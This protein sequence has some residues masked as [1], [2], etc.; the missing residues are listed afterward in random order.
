VAGSCGTGKRK[1]PGNWGKRL[2][3]EFGGTV[4]KKEK[5]KGTWEGKG[6]QLVKKNNWFKKKTGV[7]VGG[8]GGK[9]SHTIVGETLVAQPTGK[10]R[11]HQVVVG[12]GKKNRIFP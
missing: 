6:N 8:K 11:I 7:R 12:N 2:V 1:F 4:G 3:K 9:E 5:G 10:D